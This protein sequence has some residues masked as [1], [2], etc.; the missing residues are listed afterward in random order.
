MRA[1]L[2]EVRSGKPIM[3]LEFESWS[4]DTGLLAA[5]SIELRVPGY[6]PAALSLDLRSLLTPKKHGIAL[7]EDSVAGDVWVPAAGFISSAP[8]QGDVDGKHFYEVKAQGPDRLLE[9]RHV[10]LYPGWPLVNGAG[11]PNTTYDPKWRNLEYGT[12]IKRLVAESMKWPG[13]D[14]PLDFEPDRSGSRER[15]YLALDGKPVLDAMDDI[16][17]LIEGVEYDFQP[18]IDGLDQVRWRLATGRDS[19]RVITGDVNPVFNLGGVRA[20][21]RG[22]EREPVG[23]EAASEAYFT[24]G[25]ED[26]R[27][28]VARAT[29][30]ALIN[31]GWPR[32]EVWDSSHSTVSIQ[33]T[34]QSWAN[35]RLRGVVERIEFEV[36]SDRAWRMRHGDRVLLSAA[37]H[38]DMPDGVYDRR[39]L[40]V[41][42]SSDSAD[43]TTVQ[44]VEVLS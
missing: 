16:A 41:S 7:V 3:D 11:K 27:V 5:D 30:S 40:S 19:S 24:G 43:W 38:W 31:Q 25:K 22:W 17:D 12:I 15:N 42:R 1:L 10:R 26:D 32:Q 36:R 34:L 8:A 20:D 28:M 29:S 6:T 9:Q 2:F 33:S 18:Y 21:V 4:Y 37:G 23:S 39:V 35:A 44:L 14:L 13:G